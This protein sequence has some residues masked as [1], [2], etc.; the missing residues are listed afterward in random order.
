[1]LESRPIQVI[2]FLIR[3]YI[4]NYDTWLKKSSWRH[5]LTNVV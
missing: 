2:I 3:L 4:Q 1:M 5:Y